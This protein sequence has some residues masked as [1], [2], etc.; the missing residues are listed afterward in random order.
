MS[1]SKGD[2]KSA[3]GLAV[4]SGADEMPNALPPTPG[5]E[6]RIVDLHPTQMTLGYAEVLLKRQQWRQMDGAAK[7]DFLVKHPMP[8]V[9]GPKG[10]LYIVDHHHLARALLEEEVTSVLVTILAD[11]SA[12]ERDEFW[13]VMDYRQWVHPY[14]AKGRKHSCRALKKTV[15]GLRNDSYRSLAAAVR[16]AGGVEKEQTPFA[17]FLWADY[18]RRRIP[19]KLLK[20]DPSAALTEALQMAHD[21]AAKHLP[22]WIAAAWTLSDAS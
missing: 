20:T 1:M 13:N 16:M 10:R 7:G 12:L 3:P 2:D 22:G 4:E 18:F 6:V 9:L 17:E 5:G 19:A 8:A 21:K 15:S 14:D 11:L